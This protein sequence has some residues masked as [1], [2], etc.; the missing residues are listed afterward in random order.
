MLR[1]L[2][3][4]QSSEQDGNIDGGS[5]R[6]LKEVRILSM[7]RID[8]DGSL[9]AEEEQAINDIG[10]LF[11][12]YRVDCWYFG[13]ARPFAGSGHDSVGGVTDGSVMDA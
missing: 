8:W 11:R 2:R 4:A 1:E 9:G 5:R 6:R 10:F 3:H 13:M 12:N 7:P